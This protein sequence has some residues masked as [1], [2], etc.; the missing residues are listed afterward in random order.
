LGSLGDKGLVA[1]W[2]FFEWQAFSRRTFGLFFLVVDAGWKSN[3]DVVDG[4]SF[5][6]GRIG[7]ASKI[8]L[9]WGQV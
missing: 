4:N 1:V 9:A 5:D 7:V 2:R 8:Y 3:K 6:R